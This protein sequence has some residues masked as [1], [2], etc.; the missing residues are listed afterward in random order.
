VLGDPITALVWLANTLGS[1]GVTLEAG[2][3]VL[4]GSCTP[5]VPASAGDTV[6]ADFAEFGPV[7]VSFEEER[8][9]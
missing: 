1:L 2:E 5:A 6:R 7:S 9:A 4:S 3:V 8:A